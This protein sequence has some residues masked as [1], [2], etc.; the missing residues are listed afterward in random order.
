MYLNCEIPFVPTK[1]KPGYPFH[2]REL[3]PFKKKV[4]YSPI[5][6]F[7]KDV[8]DFLDFLLI[9]RPSLE[10]NDDGGLDCLGA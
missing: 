4:K 5:L 7:V 8:E 1:L 6:I 9:A 3:I 10:M 2:P